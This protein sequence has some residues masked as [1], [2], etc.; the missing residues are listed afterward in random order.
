MVGVHNH[1]SSSFKHA[2]MLAL[3]RKSTTRD[4]LRHPRHLLP[5]DQCFFVWR[6]RIVP[7][8]AV[9]MVRRVGGDDSSMYWRVT[10]IH[11]S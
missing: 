3:H 9:A 2:G 10:A 5:R 7:M 11:A 6:M 8:F 4:I 1:N